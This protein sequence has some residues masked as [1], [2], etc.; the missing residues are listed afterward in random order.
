MIALRRLS[1]GAVGH[2]GL[3]SGRTCLSQG[4]RRAGR[5]AAHNGG[6]DL[7]RCSAVAGGL[8]GL[9]CGPFAIICVPLGAG[10]GAL[11]GGTG[12]AVVGATASLSD[13]QAAQLRNRLSQAAA[14][15]TA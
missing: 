4:P 5:P 2:D 9:A 14:F 3:L 15:Q 8:W 10:I 13:G 11:A 6:P 12:G 1:A 7:R